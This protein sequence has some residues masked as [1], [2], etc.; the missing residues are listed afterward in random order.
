MSRQDTKQVDK[1][2]DNI[3]YHVKA[4]FFASKM[5]SRRLSKIREV[6]NHGDS[7][8]EIGCSSSI[9]SNDFDWVGLDISKAVLAMNKSKNAVQA[10]ALKLPFKEKYFSLVMMFNVR[11]HLHDPEV[12]LLEAIRVLKPG[13]FLA[14]GSPPLIWELLLAG[15]PSNYKRKRSLGEVFAKGLL[16]VTFVTAMLKHMKPILKEFY[17]GVKDE[18]LISRGQ[19]CYR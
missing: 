14:I 16:S 13:G 1:H 8:L 15:E 12:A 17:N 5:K 7:A 4:R 2:Y 18:V 11:E 3:E 19:K 9:Y 6:I 10:S